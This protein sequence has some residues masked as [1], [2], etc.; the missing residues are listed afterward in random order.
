MLPL[1]LSSWRDSRLV[2]A[3]GNV[4]R[5]SLAYRELLRRGQ[6]A[7]TAIRAGL[8]HRDAAIRERCC[9]LLD[10]LLVED[11]VQELVAMV[12]DE[13]AGVRVAAVHAI[14][15]DRCKQTCSPPVEALVLP[16]GMRLLET[17]P[18]PLVRALAAELVGR[19]AHENVLAAQALHQAA[20][21]DPSPAVRKKA[22]WYA[23]GGPVFRRRAA[24]RVRKRRR[25]AP[26]SASAIL[27][28]KAAPAISR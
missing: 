20:K 15:C 7:V 24:E 11:A 1:A 13:D 14:T 3:L 27:A 18:D 26:A 19:F 4:S 5:T 28:A 2:E 21:R 10:K 12:H 25:T 23:P 16:L 6:L 8:R 9:R 22:Y 17:D